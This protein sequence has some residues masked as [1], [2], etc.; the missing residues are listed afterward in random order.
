MAGQGRHF[1]LPIDPLLAKD[2]DL[3]SNPCRN[4]GCSDIVSDVKA[5]LCRETRVLLTN[6][7]KFL[8]S[9]VS[10]ISLTLNRVRVLGPELLKRSTTTVNQLKGRGIYNNTLI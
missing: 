3:W 1:R 9:A 5:E 2:R 4:H 10:V 8:I 6:L 7:I